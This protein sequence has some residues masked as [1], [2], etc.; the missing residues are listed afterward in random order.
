MCISPLFPH[1]FS[2][3]ASAVLAFF[4]TSLFFS[5]SIWISA[6]SLAKWLSGLSRS[7]E[8]VSNSATFPRS[9]TRTRSLS[10]MVYSLCATTI[11]VQS[12]KLSLIS[13]WITCSVSIS[14]FAV[15]S[16]R[17][18]ILFFLRIAR[19]MQTSDFSPELRFS[20][21]AWI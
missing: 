1:F 4:S 15:A 7:T 3:S 12:L 16:S 19:Q 2:L 10:I 6:M 8:G 11:I 13:F 21:P 17:I 5:S 9:R 14:I 20:P 18:T